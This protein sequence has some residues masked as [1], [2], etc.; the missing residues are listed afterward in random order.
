MV[1]RC[2]AGVA[3]CHSPEFFEEVA[4]FVRLYL[5]SD[6]DPSSYEFLTC[7]FATLQDRH[8]AIVAT[9]FRQ[10]PSYPQ[11]YH[12][13]LAEQPVLEQ[14]GVTVVPLAEPKRPTCFTERDLALRVF[15]ERGSRRWVDRDGT[16]GE[17]AAAG[18]RPARKGARATPAGA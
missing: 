12:D 10:F 15:T 14:P 17:P 13:R 8:G 1:G 6:P 3:R 2:D 5:A 4:E 11:R 7:D 16:P 18:V 9:T